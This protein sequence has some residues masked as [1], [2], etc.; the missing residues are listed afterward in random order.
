MTERATISDKQRLDLIRA[1]VGSAG[2]DWLIVA[3]RKTISIGRDWL[4]FSDVRLTRIMRDGPDGS[5]DVLHFAETATYDE[6]ELVMNAPKDIRFLIGL[7]DRSVAKVRDLLSRLP[8]QKDYT[9]QAAM[10]CADPAFKRFMAEK[11]DLQSPLTDE[12]VA[13]RLRSVLRI[14]SRAD[15]NTSDPAA[16]RWKGLVKSF[17]NWKRHG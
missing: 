15:L 6:R 3:D 9:A 13:T 2:N 10:L 14:S 4:I 11:H 5:D 1:R 17:E 7:V 12:R 16:E 8:E